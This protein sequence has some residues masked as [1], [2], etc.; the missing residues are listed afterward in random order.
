MDL[1]VQ[2]QLAGR[3]LPGER[4]LWTGQPRQGLVFTGS[5]IP[6]TLFFLLWGGVP[7]L[8]AV[9]EISGGRWGMVPFLMPFI[10]IGF[11]M[12]VL[13][14]WHDAWFR[15]YT[16]YAIT[17]RRILIWRNR[18]SR[19][20]RSFDRASAPNVELVEDGARGTL[21]FGPPS[22]GGRFNVLRGDGS[23]PELFGIDNARGVFDLLLRTQPRAAA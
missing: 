12:L 21:R 22:N 6:I 3:L 10:L 7:S 9:T 2:R 1:E 15:G 8:A 23:G 16:F 5:D 11:Y 19:T 18:Y 17:D 13:R 4:I 20:F 14:F